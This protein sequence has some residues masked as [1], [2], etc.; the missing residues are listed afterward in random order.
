M[1]YL[2]LYHKQELRDLVNENRA[3]KGLPK[4][5]NILVVTAKR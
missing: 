5:E 3:G 1:P 2:N 4:I